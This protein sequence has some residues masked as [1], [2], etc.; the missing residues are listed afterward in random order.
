MSFQS[1]ELAR[2][3]NVEQYKKQAK[4]LVR[5]RREAG[6]NRQQQ[7]QLKR[8]FKM[9]QQYHPQFRGKTEAEIRGAE[10]ALS[11]AQLVIARE[12]GFLSWPKF[13][14]AIEARRAGL[15][16]EENAE[17]AFL[18]AASV[19]RGEDHD[20]AGATTDAAEAVRK[21]HPGV[22]IESVWAA[23]VYGDAA[24]VKAFLAKDKGLASQRGGVYAWDPLTYLCFSRYA[25]WLR[26]DEARSRA[27]V[28]AARAL[29]EAG[30]DVDTGWFDGI[31]EATPAWESVLYGAAG[32]AQHAE[33]TRLLLEYGADPND[34]ETAYHAAENYEQGPVRALLE[35]GKLA[36]G[37]KT[38]LLVRKA[39]WHD[40]EG[41]KLV[42]EFGGN[43]H[44]GTQWKNTAFAWSVKRDNWIELVK[45]MLADAQ[46]PLSKQ[47]EEVQASILGATEQAVRRGRPDLLKLLDERGLMPD[48]LGFDRLLEACARG[49]LEK[50]K[51]V[52]AADPAALA[53][54][55]AHGGALLSQ[56]AGTGCV[57][58]MRVLMELGVAAA[59]L[60]LEG[61]PYF[62]IAKSGT[63]LHSGAWRLQ[64]GA[65]KLLLERGVP[66]DAKDERGRTAL[67][68]AVRACVD[69]YWKSRR[70]PESIAM[71]LEAGASQ[72]SVS[73]PT[74]YAEA[75]ALLRRHGG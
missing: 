14:R 62:E 3:P 2:V 6:E 73:V 42:L 1:R 31:G 71:L 28:D 56:Y 51:A 74:G 37:G 26:K 24:A 65:V 12:H 8:L 20:G 40:L 30:A 21:A 53:M 58:G 46:G 9:I 35:S 57:E 33:L 54:V 61:D 70:S 19:P 69:S 32:V 13:V 59:A 55:L 17:A 38:T 52:A 34:E 41:A 18:R 11:D 22:E 27:F 63:A 29:L 67:M 23:A 49:D 7:M 39:D 66:V 44:R 10:F 72:E 50:A 15:E 16:A 5:F 25:R 68:F 60:N 48:L 36:E 4:E 75:D 45:T 64:H 47:T 43:P